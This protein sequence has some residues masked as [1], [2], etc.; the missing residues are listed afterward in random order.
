VK[1]LFNKETNSLDRS[2][3]YRDETSTDLKSYNSHNGKWRTLHSR[4]AL[5]LLSY[6]FDH[7][8]DDRNLFT[9]IKNDFKSALEDKIYPNSLMKKL[10]FLF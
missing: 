9:K 2:V 4:W 3:L 8:K 5:Q 10:S 7:Y 1:L 6:L